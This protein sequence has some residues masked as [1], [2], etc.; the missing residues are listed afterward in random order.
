M[1]SE[2]RSQLVRIQILQILLDCAG[3]LLPEPAFFA[4]LNLA[5]APAVTFTEFNQ[6][7][8]CL[9]AEGYI[10][11]IRPELGGPL[12]WKITDKGRAAL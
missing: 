10:L 6:Q 8:K 4:Q 5:I 7:T 1:T 2:Q 9:E 12:K 3:Y 11:G